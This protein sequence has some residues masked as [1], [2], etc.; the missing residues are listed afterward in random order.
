MIL[1]AENMRH[2]DRELQTEP[3]SG[4][5][6]SD[7]QEKQGGEKF[8][9]IAVSRK[10]FRELSCKSNVRTNLVPEDDMKILKRI[11]CVEFNDDIHNP[12]E[13]NGQIMALD[14]FY[15]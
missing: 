7:E 10:P 1:A 13:L 9:K 4:T 14:P 6:K 5:Y 8:E 15:M 12:E 11:I 2:H 3:S